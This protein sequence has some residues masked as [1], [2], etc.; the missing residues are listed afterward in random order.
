MSGGA[1]MRPLSRKLCTLL[2]EPAHWCPG[3]GRLHL[4]SAA[5]GW[6]WNGDSERPTFTPVMRQGLQCHYTLKDGVLR[7][8]SDC[9]H[10]LAGQTVPLPDLPEKYQ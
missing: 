4:P 6:Q 8:F 7:F 2:G 5:A 1:V 10:E 3:C 9:A